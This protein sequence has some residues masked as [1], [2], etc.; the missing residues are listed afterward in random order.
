MGIYANIEITN[1]EYK[2]RYSSLEEAVEQWEDNLDVS[3]P[4]AEEVIES[5]LSE[6][7]IEEDGAL[8]SK[9][10]MR[11]AMILWMKNVAKV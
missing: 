8:W 5:H 10:E 1:S 3:T 9:R 2:Q 4:D 7:L 11:S 6:N